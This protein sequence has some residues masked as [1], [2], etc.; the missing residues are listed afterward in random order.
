M[1]LTPSVIEKLGYDPRKPTDA[2][3]GSETKIKILK[4]RLEYGLPLHLDGDNLTQE[5]PAGDQMQRTP[6]TNCDWHEYHD[7][8]L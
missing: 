7:P 8:D 4:S 5:L 2:A 1:R 3:P 6:R